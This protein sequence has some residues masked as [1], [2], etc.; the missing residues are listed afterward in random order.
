MD[1]IEQF[2][3]EVRG[4]AHDPFLGRTSGTVR[5]DLTNGNGNG[6]DQ[7]VIFIDK[8]DLSV[9]HRAAKA[10]TVV[11]TDRRLFERIVNGKANAM[12]LMLR[13]LVFAEGDP[14]LAVLARRLFAA[15]GMQAGSPP[16]PSG[17]SSGS[18]RAPTGSDRSPAASDR[19]SSGRKRGARHV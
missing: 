18:D 16:M 15:S 6:V 3:A 10:D 19:R 7:W 14:E 12:A 5:F 8:G 17:A 13:G 2:F 11:R 4:R 1:T 9:S